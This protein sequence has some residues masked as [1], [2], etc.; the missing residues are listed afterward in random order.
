MWLL[1]WIIDKSAT[2]NAENSVLENLEIKFVFVPGHAQ[3]SPL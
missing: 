2:E 3:V 1:D